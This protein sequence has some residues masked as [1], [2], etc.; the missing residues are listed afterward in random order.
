MRAEA[1]SHTSK[2]IVVQYFNQGSNDQGHKALAVITPLGIVN[3]V[4][5]MRFK[6]VAPSSGA[7]FCS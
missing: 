7:D 1:L 4:C 6:K 5:M 3:I 2:V